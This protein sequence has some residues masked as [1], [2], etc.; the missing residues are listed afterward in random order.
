M[1]LVDGGPDRGYLQN[2]KMLTSAPSGRQRSKGWEKAG[3][4]RLPTRQGKTSEEMFFLVAIDAEVFPIRS[5]RR[6]IQVISILMMDGEEAPVLVV[7]F[8]SA[9]AADETMD[10]EGSLPVITVGRFGLTHFLKQFINGLETTDF[11]HSWKPSIIT[12]LYRHGHF[13]PAIRD[14]PFQKA[15]PLRLATAVRG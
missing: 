13:L 12:A 1:I 5:I 9:P 10:L 6:V 11:L 2:R 4:D 15:S 8:P 3:L 14:P 7:K